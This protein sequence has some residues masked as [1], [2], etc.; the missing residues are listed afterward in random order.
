[1]KYKV[2]DKVRI[3]SLDWYNENKD[4]YGYVN[5]REN[6]DSHYNFFTGQSDFCG[7]VITIA[8]VSDN[9][10]DAIEDDGYWFWT[11]EMIEGLVEEKITTNE[12]QFSISN[13]PLEKEKEWNLP[14]GYEFRDENGNPINAKKIVLE[15]KKP[16]YPQDYEKC[17][18][19][20]GTHPSRSVDSTFITDLTDYEDNLSNLMSDLY[21][22][23]ICRNAYWKIAGEELELGKPWKPDWNDYENIK[24]IVGGYDGEIGYDQNHHIHKILAFHTEEM[25]D[26][27]Y[28]NFKDLIE[29]CKELL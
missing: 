25:R 7:E 5:L 29:Q 13:V 15:K 1:M 3:K 24:Y 20:L 9:F 28:G 23:L 22:L 6:T 26:V 18:E 16:K 2:G 21:K 27:F 4:D 8:K 14:E 17:C 10:Y 19:V 11:D 12:S